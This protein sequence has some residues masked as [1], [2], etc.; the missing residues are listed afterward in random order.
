M[1]VI[2]NYRKKGTRYGDP[3]DALAD[4]TRGTPNLAAI[5]ARLTAAATGKR[6]R[7]SGNRIEAML[8][9][10]H[11]TY[12]L[13]GRAMI[14][15]HHPPVTG[16]PGALRFSGAG[17]VDYSGLIRTPGHGRMMAIDAKGIT[18]Q[19]SLSVRKVMPISHKNHKA[20]LRERERLIRQAQLLVDFAHFGALTAFLC[21][22]TERERAWLMTEVGRIARGEDVPIRSRDRDLWPA[23]P[24]ATVAE[25]AQGAPQIDYLSVWPDLR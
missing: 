16:V 23:V 22:D 9:R 14:V 18:G 19:S 4:P 3:R 20:S 21:V 17:H 13:T 5:D 12:L 8:E 25:I 10:T 24:F 7:D 11:Q 2:R 15:H 6:R 1:M